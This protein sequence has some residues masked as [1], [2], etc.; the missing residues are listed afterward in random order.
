MLASHGAAYALHWRERSG[1]I[2]RVMGSGR[3]SLRLFE[4]YVKKEN[5]NVKLKAWIK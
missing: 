5:H 2:L 1:S 4:K 3:G